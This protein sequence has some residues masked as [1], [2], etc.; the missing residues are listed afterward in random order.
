M[1]GGLGSVVHDGF[2]LLGAGGMEERRTVR[3]EP[4]MRPVSAEKIVYNI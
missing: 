2:Q 1:P 3:A 4:W